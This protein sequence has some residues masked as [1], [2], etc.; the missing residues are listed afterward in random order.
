MS[1]ETRRIELPLFALNT[2]LYPGGLLPLKVT[3]VREHRRRPR[4]RRASLSGSVCER[5][6]STRFEPL[7]PQQRPRKRG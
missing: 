7:D 4:A 5:V 6:I 1:A 3:R 2:V